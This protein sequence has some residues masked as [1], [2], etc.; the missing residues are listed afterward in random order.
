MYIYDGSDDLTPD[1][2]NGGLT[3]TKF[4]LPF[5]STASDGAL[6]FKFYSDEYTVASGWNATISC[7]SALGTPDN[8]FV[9]YSYYP[10]P[11]SKNIVIASK[12]Q[13]N[14]TSVYNIEGRLLYREQTNALSTTIDLSKFASGTYFIKLKFEQNEANFKVLKM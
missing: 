8:S 4:L 3:G 14:H 13:I 11:T 7:E 12:D 6:T 5:I 1:L 10:N 2:T 9:D